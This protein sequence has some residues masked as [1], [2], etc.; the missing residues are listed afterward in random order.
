MVVIVKNVINITL[1]ELNRYIIYIGNDSF[2]RSGTTPEEALKNFSSESYYGIDVVLL[3][4]NMHY[5]GGT[6]YPTNKKSPC[7]NYGDVDGD[8]YV[9]ILDSL[10]IAQ[11]TVGTVILSPE[12]IKRGDVNADGF[13]TIT[14]S[15]YIAQYILGTR[16]T[17]PV[18][19]IPTL[20]LPGIIAKDIGNGWISVDVSTTGAGTGKITIDGVEKE[21]FTVTSLQTGYSTYFYVGIATKT[22][23]ICAVVI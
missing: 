11:Y 12:Q 5:S 10:L 21:R 7:S 14:D 18:C 13:L 6:A 8:G 15:L 2:L 9:T 22:Y 17:F 3:W 1:H 16:I 4:Q 23:E 19:S 20:V